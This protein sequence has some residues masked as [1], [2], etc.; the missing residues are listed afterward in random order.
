METNRLTRIYTYQRAYE[1]EES[2]MKMKT[3][4]I[5]AGVVAV[6]IAGMTAIPA[7]A[8]EKDSSADVS[9]VQVY[10]GFSVMHERSDDKAFY[11]AEAIY[12]QAELDDETAAEYPAL[13]DAFSRLNEEKRKN[14][15]ETFQSLL[16]DLK[17][18]MSEDPDYSA[19]YTDEESFFVVRADRHIVSLLSVSSGYSGGAHGYAGYSGVN[20]D[21][22]SGNR[23]ELSELITD[24]KAFKALVK[25]EINRLYPEVE[26][27]LTDRYFEETAVN[28][29]IW[30]AGCEGVTCYFNAYTLGPYAIGA[31]TVLIPYEGN[32]ELFAGTAADVPENYGVEIPFGYPVKIGGRELIVYGTRGENEIY[33]TVSISLDGEVAY[34]DDN[35][36]AN[37][38]RPTYIRSNGEDYLYLQYS[39]DNDWRYLEIFRLGEKTERVGEADLAAAP[40]FVEEKSL[41]VTAAMTNPEHL[42]LSARLW[43]FEISNQLRTYRVGTDGM[44][45]ATEPYFHVSNGRVLTAKEELSC[46]E[47]DEEGNVIGT[48]TVPAGTKMTPIRT[49]E[50]SLVDLRL[51]DGRI[52]RVEESSG[53][54]PETIDGK[55]IKDIF[56][57]I[58]YAG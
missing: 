3:R 7:M 24:E 34:S 54:W 2:L 51:E 15:E 39:E 52:V 47:V 37:V 16:K 8:E 11:P 17:E 36:Y 33:N 14:S 58:F 10:T 57:G 38:I 19:Y 27:D 9:S 32:E 29:M 40:M 5:L 31:Q 25:D 43:L 44:P 49:D 13:A 23:L 6:I 18:R 56:D 35:I 20:F 28:D 41:S 22:E 30:T 12:P 53:S 45:E 50:V 55:D 26:A 1:E 42:L 4:S 48:V 46:Q 21:P